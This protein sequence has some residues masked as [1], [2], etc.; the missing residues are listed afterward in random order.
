MKLAT[1]QMLTNALANATSIAVENRNKLTVLEMLLQKR[2]PNLYQE[3]SAALDKVRK[4]PPI[5]LSLVGFEHLQTKLVQ[6]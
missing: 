5:A 3:Y 6:D 1:A 4:A 2:D